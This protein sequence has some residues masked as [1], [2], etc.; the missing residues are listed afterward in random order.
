M[1]FQIGDLLYYTG[2]SNEDKSRTCGLIL[3][4]PNKDF[5]YFSVK[6]ADRYKS[7][8]LSEEHINFQIERGIFKH[9]P[10]KNFPR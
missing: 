8:A 10:R 7:V 5:N 9:F 1:N 6:W 4:L 2:S 3:S